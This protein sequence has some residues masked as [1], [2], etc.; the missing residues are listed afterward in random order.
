MT[1]DPSLITIEY[2]GENRHGK[3]SWRAVYG[4]HGAI[5]SEGRLSD[6]LASIREIDAILSEPEIPSELSL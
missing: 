6:V 1:H 5:Y 2:L 3:P 4:P